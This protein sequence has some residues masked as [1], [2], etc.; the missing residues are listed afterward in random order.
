MDTLYL[1][2]LIVGNINGMLSYGIS[3]RGIVQLG[4]YLRTRGDKVDFVKLENWLRRLHIRR[5]AQLQGSILMRFF[6]FEQDEL[7]FVRHVEK[8][9]IDLHYKLFTST[10]KTKGKSSLSKTTSDWYKPKGQAC[11][12]R[13][14]TACDISIRTLGDH[15]RPLPEC[16]SLALRT[17]RISW[18]HI[19][20][21]KKQ[22]FQT[23]MS[24]IFITLRYESYIIA[25][26]FILLPYYAHAQVQCEDTCKHI[27]GIDISHYQRTVSGR[28]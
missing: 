5:M 20:I 7:P 28:H 10:S 3:L 22:G 21:A 26:L 24:L 4:N 2:R 1:L 11:A 25:F 13:Y 18:K 9:P 17:R 16:H 23:Y 27:H 19:I 15:Q 14:S 6:N 8:E 12:N